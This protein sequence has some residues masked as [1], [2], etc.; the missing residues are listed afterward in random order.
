[1]PIT[2]LLVDDHKIFRESLRLLLGQQAEFQVVAEASNGV[3]ALAQIERVRPNVVVLDVAMPQ[4]NG[5][6]ALR[7]IRQRFA[8]V[9]VVVLSTYNE[10]AYVIDALSHGASAYV[11]KDQGVVDLVLA[12]RAAMAGYRY[13][14]PPLSERGLEIYLSA[15][16]QEGRP[17]DLSQLPANTLTKR[18]QQILAMIEQ[19]MANTEIG[20]RLNI[21][22]RTV[23]THRAHLML[24]LG[25]QT[26][27]E[28]TQFARQQKAKLRHD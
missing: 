27:G 21:S 13:L 26:R 14:S 3:E 20:R 11:L 4:L 28:L 9:R 7:Q 1:M 12:V 23:E 8:D 22:A 16:R 25:L 5:L 2:I 6:D 19:G 18:E 17:P 24:K 15:N 10:E